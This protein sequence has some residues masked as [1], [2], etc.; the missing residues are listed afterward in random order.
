MSYCS[1]TCQEIHRAHHSVY[2]SAIESLENL[3]RE[4]LYRDFSV[5]QCQVDFGTKKKLLRLVG[6]KSLLNC[7]LGTKRVEVLWDTGAMVCVIDRE[8][9]R[10]NFPD[11]KI[12]SISDFLD[13][14]LEVRAANS[15]K[16]P[17]MKVMVRRMEKG[18]S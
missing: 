1:K 6:R 11:A 14:D 3:E 9:L 15:T 13:E 12:Q 4:K 2:C 17:R 8:W 18:R 7:I 16:I 10:K 5:R